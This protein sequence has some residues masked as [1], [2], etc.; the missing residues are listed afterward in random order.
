MIFRTVQ[1]RLRTGKT[2][3]LLLGPR[4]VGKATVAHALDPGRVINLADQPT[5][6][7]YA[8]DPAR[9]RRELG[10]LTHPSLVLI[11]Q[12]QRIPSL[13]DAI[14]SEIDQVGRHRFI[15][16]ASSA[17][18]LQR[19]GDSPS[20]G[21]ITREHLDPLSVWE[22]G[23]AFDLERALQVGT[24]PGAYLDHESGLDFLDSYATAY[25]RDEVQGEALIRDVGSYARFLDIAAVESG[26]FIN[27]SKL[28]RDTG[29][30]KETIRRFF[31]ILEETLLVFRIPPVPSRQ[32]SRRINQRDRI[33]FLDLGV[34]NA[35]LGTHRHPP[36]PSQKAKLFEQWFILQCLYL[37]RANHLPWRVYSF[38]TEQGAEVDLIIDVGK[39]YLAIDCRLGRDVSASQ[40][41]GLRSFAELA[42]K[43]VKRFVV[44][45][46]DKPQRLPSGVEVVVPYLHFLLHTLPDL[47]AWIGE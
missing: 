30:A 21:K 17:R 42:D 18:K 6:L 11:H 40:L 31:Q 34:R 44:F 35:L 45:Q 36:A 37:I 33:V 41:G 43:P 25:L 7:A 47:A 28:S 19:G 39:F 9:L 29:I 32:H 15:L 46:G 1:D 16:T 24:L 3:V 8:K 22:L 26:N 4:K 13:L 27:Y 5:H 10:T 2:S 23:E 12:V 14:Q 38:R 20:S